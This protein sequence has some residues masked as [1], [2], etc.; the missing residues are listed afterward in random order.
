MGAV[1]GVDFGR[2]GTIA[3]RSYDVQSKVTENTL[4]WR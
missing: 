3:Q 4:W 2:A 1:L